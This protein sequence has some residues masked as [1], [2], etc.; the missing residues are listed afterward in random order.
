MV[1]AHHSKLGDVDFEVSAMK[2][3]G[4][5]VYELIVRA[6]WK[7]TKQVVL[8]SLPNNM[9]VNV[10]VLGAFVEG[11]VVR[12]VPCGLIITVKNSRKIGLNL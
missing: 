2:S 6:D 5:N 1:D 9:T 7:K 8:K 3:F 11:G 10:Y 4:K 12:D